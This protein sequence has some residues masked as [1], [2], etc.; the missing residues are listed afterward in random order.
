MEMPRTYKRCNGY[1]AQEFVDFEAQLNLLGGGII[2]SSPV[3]AAM[4][5]VD[6]ADFCDVSPYQDSPQ[7]IGCNVTISAPHMHAYGEIR[8]AMQS[9]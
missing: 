1:C 2:T 9:N 7:G 5:A 4:R 8:I 3:E 6:R